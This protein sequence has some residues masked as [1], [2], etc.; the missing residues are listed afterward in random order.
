M[1]RIGDYTVQRLLGTGGMGSVY[2]ARSLSGR[3]VAIK[4]IR[5]EYADDVRFR[6][7]FRQEV[8]AA[9]K[10]GGF[11]TAA[12]VD[13]D[14]DAP[15]PWMA[16]AYIEGPTLHA[17]VARSGPLSEERL[18]RLAAALAE[19]LEA[20]HARG[21][22]HR[23]LKP[24]NIVLAS[25]GPRVLDFGVAR[26]VEESRLTTDGVV[27]G[28]AGY[29]SPEQAL[30]H[31]VTGASDLFA[32]GAVLIA[33]A[34][35][36][37]FGHGSTPGLMYRVVH[38][39][40]DVS[41]VPSSLRPL[42]LACLRKDP[43][44]RP[45]PRGLLALCAERVGAPPTHE[46]TV[47]DDAP[48]PT[49]PPTPPPPPPPTVSASSP[50]PAREAEDG[51]ADPL[52]ASAPPLAVYHVRRSVWFL[53]ILRNMLGIAGLVC[54]AVLGG[55]LDLPIALQAVAGIAAFL[56]GIRLL[57]LLGTAKDGLTLN[58]RGIGVGPHNSLVVIPWHEIRALELTR[59]AG[60]TDLSLH[61]DVVRPL[62]TGFQHPT[63]VR[64]SRG[65]TRISTR[66][67]SPLGTAPRLPDAVH[68]FASRHRVRVSEGQ[69]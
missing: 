19:A 14:P 13:A 7:R 30:G 3:L 50:G 35:G 17:E 48:P 10:V 33:A 23:D 8:E 4:V 44:D 69:G 24:A 26:A 54:G 49:P 5:P 53:Q 40:P 56:L 12:V 31:P 47:V 25:D 37:A 22:V 43:A 18:W 21:L 51:A 57:G 46:A 62:P 6:D 58:D 41:V 16:S 52:R 55:T 64:H 1:E 61:L 59:H 45:S 68:A 20:I 60:W 27:V 34:G 63:W 2:L 29:H 11:H 9:R 38:E 39:D 42:V 36:S 28:T 32:L 65:V 66:R 67:L 15:Q